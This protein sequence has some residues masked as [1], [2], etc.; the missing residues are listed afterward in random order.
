MDGFGGD[1]MLL[2]DIPPSFLPQHVH[3][4]A[5]AT[6]AASKREP[7][8]MKTMVVQQAQNDFELSIKGRKH[9]PGSPS[10]YPPIIRRCTKN[11]KYF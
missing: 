7:H 6:T 1:N 8:I 3:S 2:G 11:T 5:S 10:K 9:A 4:L